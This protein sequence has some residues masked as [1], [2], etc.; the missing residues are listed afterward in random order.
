MGRLI[1]ASLSIV[2]MGLIGVMGRT[3]SRVNRCV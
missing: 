3:N 2:G 1:T